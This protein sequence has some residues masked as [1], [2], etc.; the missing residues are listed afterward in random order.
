MILLAG[1]KV[2]IFVTSL[3]NCTFVKL[4]LRQQGTNMY[5]DAGEFDGDAVV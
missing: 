2:Y 1:P 3:T 5:G 4:Q